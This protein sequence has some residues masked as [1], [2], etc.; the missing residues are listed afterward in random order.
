ML[1]LNVPHVSYPSSN[2]M[3]SL[4]RLTRITHDLRR[5]YAIAKPL[6]Y[7]STITVRTAMLMILLAWLTPSCISF[8]PILLGW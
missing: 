1:W 7:H 4:K 3:T 6:V 5:Y 8:L 2:Q